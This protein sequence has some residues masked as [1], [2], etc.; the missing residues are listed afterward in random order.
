MK[1]IVLSL[2]FAVS[3]AVFIGGGTVCAREFG[4]GTFPSVEATKDV[5]V[6]G[7]D[8]WNNRFREEEFLDVVKGAVNRVLGILALIA[9]IV[10]LYGGFL[11]VTAAGDDDQYGKWWKIL[12]AAAIWLT[13]IGLAWLIITFFFR[14]TTVTWKAAEGSTAGTDQ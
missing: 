2:F 7:A 6:G 12:R 9:L 8:W 10:L 4:F 13:I 5:Q 3:S 11:M 14:L 1:K